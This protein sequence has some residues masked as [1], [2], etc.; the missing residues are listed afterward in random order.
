M[1]RLVSGTVPYFSVSGQRREVVTDEA[2]GKL[3]D[4]G[5]VLESGIRFECLRL[6]DAEGFATDVYKREGIVCEIHEVSR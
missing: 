5:V 4:S 1:R 3:I 6:Q 2:S